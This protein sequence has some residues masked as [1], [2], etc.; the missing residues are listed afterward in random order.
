MRRTSFQYICTF[1]RHPTSKQLETKEL[2][3]LQFHACS[4]AIFPRWT[5]IPRLLVRVP[6][7]QRQHMRHGRADDAWLSPPA[8]CVSRR[9]MRKPQHFLSS[10]ARVHAHSSGD[11]SRPFQHALGG[12]RSETPKASATSAGSAARM[13][14]RCLST[15]PKIE[16]LT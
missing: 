1:Y 16:I 13:R 3:C 6:P 2:P 11:M 10:L 12:L 14:A 7:L 4:T 15:F 8:S 5:A 9:R